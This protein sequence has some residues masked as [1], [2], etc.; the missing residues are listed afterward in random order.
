MQNINQRRWL[1]YAAVILLSLAALIFANYQFAKTSPGG[2]D[3]LV[4]WEGTRNFFTTGT[5]PYSDDTALKIQTMVYGRAAEAGEHE[6]R[7]AYPLYSLFFFAPFA[8]IK[9]FT[10]ARAVW[11]AIL[12]ICLVLIAILSFRLT[13]W[14]P[15]PL[16]FALLVLFTLFSYHGTR[17]L[18]NG[19]AVIV[20]T[21]L[22][23]AS[24]L[25]IR[26]GKDEIAGILLAISTIKPQNV[27]LLIAFLLFWA[28]FNKR[29]RLIGYFLG[30]MVILVGFSF[31][32]IPDWLTQNFREILR[33]PSYNPPG[34]VGAV[35]I[36]WWG[37][38]GT[39][40]S[41]ALSGVLIVLL[42][43]EWWLGRYAANK[44]F[45]WVAFLTL[46][47]SQWIGIQTDP[48]NF[49]L[50]YPGLFFCMEMISSRWKQK[51]AGF[52]VTLVAVLTVGIWALFL[53]TVQKSYQ[54][55][56]SSLLFFPLPI[57]AFLLLYWV[58]WWTTHSRN[59]ELPNQT[60]EI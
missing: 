24:L 56:Q 29:Y 1:T 27:V 2:T 31:L 39:R 6:L 33:Y 20:V 19:N 36:S 14:K 23:L 12:E 59:I 18:I 42:G 50:L 32:L 30:S 43:L 4:H 48:G 11:M 15:S 17:P 49:I 58:R 13:Y 16:L 54:P 40:L 7:V 26:D 37:D 8:L 34:T 51:S 25:M 57:V 35:M 28:F 55:I 22:L 41:Y 5:S 52:L 47:L 10:L 3:F 46:A 44:Y 45:L 21:L 9:D 38:I 53:A 60:L